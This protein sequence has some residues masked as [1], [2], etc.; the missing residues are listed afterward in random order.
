MDSSTRPSP[1]SSTMS[2]VAFPLC[3]TTTSPGTN[4]REE[5]AMMRPTQT[6]GTTVCWSSTLQAKSLLPSAAHELLN[7]A[8]V[9]D[10]QMHGK[11]V[12]GTGPI[13]SSRLHGWL[14]LGCKMWT[15][16]CTSVVKAKWGMPEDC[17]QHSVVQSMQS[18]LLM[19]DHARDTSLYGV[20]LTCLCCNKL[21]DLEKCVHPAA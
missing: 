18:T 3:T 19:Q 1:L 4:R 17:R 13:S 12:M 11:S 21:P 5:S 15:C 9:V 20:Q 2:H 14:Q 16:D 7:V 6:K 8:A 10:L